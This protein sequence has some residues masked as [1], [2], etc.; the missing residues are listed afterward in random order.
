VKQQSRI[1]V[2]AAGSLAGVTETSFGVGTARAKNGWGG[3]CTG[4]F[5]LH[6]VVQ[7][8]QTPASKPTVALTELMTGIIFTSFPFH[9]L[10]RGLLL[11]TAIEIVT[12][13]HCVIVGIFA[14][15]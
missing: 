8:G 4:Y 11:F 15:L 3:A 6:S 7:A 13:C 9:M 2:A 5:L 1:C 12:H 14:E 10:V